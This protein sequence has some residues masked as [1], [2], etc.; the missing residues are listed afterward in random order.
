MVWSFWPFFRR[1][2]SQFI[3]SSF[4]K[5]LGLHFVIVS[6]LFWVWEMSLPVRGAWERGGFGEAVTLKEKDC[7]QKNQSPPQKKK[8]VA[9][10][11]FIWALCPFL[12]DKYRFACGSWRFGKRWRAATS[13]GWFGG[14]PAG[15]ASLLSPVPQFRRR[16]SPGGRGWSGA[17]PPMF[18]GP[19]LQTLGR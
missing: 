5:G 3:F 4:A 1:Y 6:I 18:V 12:Y 11:H 15:A 17:S 14:G 2:F 16:F 19:Y 10:S 8:F 7:T 9:L 13:A